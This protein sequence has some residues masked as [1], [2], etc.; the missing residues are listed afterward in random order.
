MKHTQR[1]PIKI[2]TLSS[3]AYSNLK[4]DVVSILCGRNNSGKSYILK[5]MYDELGDKTS[6][7]GPNRYQN[8]NA[9]ALVSGK[10]NKSEQYLNWIKQFR[11][12]QQ[13]VDNSPWNLQQA[14]AELGNNKRQILFEILE[15]LLGSKITLE[16]SDPDNEMSQRFVSVDG[17]NISYTSAGYRLITSIL[18]SLLDEDYENFLI[19]EPELG[20]SPEIQ[21]VLAEFLFEQKNRDNYFPHLKKLVVAT[22]S[23]VFLDRKNFRR[24]YYIDRIEN[25]ININQISNIQEINSL[26]FFLLGNRFET[27]FLP[28]VI[29]LVEGICDYKFLN[30]L[31]KR[32]YPNSNISVIHCNSDNRIAEYVNMAKTMFGDLHKSP[33]HN[34]IITVIDKIHTNGLKT[35]LLGQGI[36]EDSIIIWEKNGIEYYYPT[37]ILETIFGAYKELEIEKDIIKANDIPKKKSELVDEV[38]N[39]LTGKENF[40]DEFNAKLIQRIDS[41]IY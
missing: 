23:P 16:L 41:L 31:I 33:Y 35:K 8:F 14:I 34:R 22:H 1:P 11:S 12:N 10:R 37:E 25:E 5:T 38:V 40:N 18:T 2:S 27:L 4:A 30:P 36:N 24:N 28:S 20:I 26:Q 15:N 3:A 21:G 39:K 29:L 17:Y 9:L 7:L 13:N 6:F 32:K 19:D